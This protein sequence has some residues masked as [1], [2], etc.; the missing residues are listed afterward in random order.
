MKTP[1]QSIIMPYHRDKSI[2]IYTTSLLEKIIP[3]EVEIIIVGNN[4]N[5]SELDVDLSSRFRFI[6][7]NESMLYSR[8]V[9]A[10]VEAA[11]GEIITLCDQDIYGYADWYTPLLNKLVNNEKIGSVSSKLLNPT[12]N[13]IIDFGIEYSPRNI[14][15]TLRGHL[16]DHPLAQHD[17]QVT[18]TTSATFMTW[19]AVYSNISGMDTDMP[20]CCS[21]CDIGFKVHEEGYE[22]WVVASSIAYHRGSSSSQNGKSQS[23]SHLI[24]DSHNA[25]WIKN[26]HRVKPTVREDI[27]R[28]FKYISKSQ[29]FLPLY[30]FINLSTL[31]EYKWYGEQLCDISG[32]SIADYHSYKTV[33]SNYCDMIQLY[34]CVPYSFM[35]VR[36]PLIYFVNYFPCLQ[37]NIIWRKM[38]DTQQ[39]IVMDQHGNIVMLNDVI[40]SKC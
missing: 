11:N 18:S 35:N 38:R 36:V 33:Q 9:N 10:G 7:F 39:D 8:S 20:Y 34:D 40:D 32:F 17:R 12:N 29:S 31:Y 19:K 3:A 24:H 5:K 6:K 25:F 14:T 15:H 28:S 30:I 21:D 13:R 26:H 4:D 1:S 23:F 16:S 37:N 27:K 2:L 22:N